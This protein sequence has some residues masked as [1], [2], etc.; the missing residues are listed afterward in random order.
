MSQPQ[1]RARAEA[2]QAI[3]AR[4]VS[5]DDAM[6]EIRAAGLGDTVDRT[7]KVLRQWSLGSP[8]SNLGRGL[9]SRAQAEDKPAP[10]PSADRTFVDPSPER[11]RPPA[12]PGEL[13][14]ILFIP[15]AHHPFVDREAWGVMLRAAKRFRPDVVVILGDFWDCYAVSAHDKDP[16][17]LSS[18]AS[19]ADTVREA[20]DEVLAIG[21]RRICYVEGN[22]EWRLPRYIA[23]QAQALHGL[24]TVP[25]LL[26]L[27]ERGIEWTPYMRSLRIGHLTITHDVGEAGIY[28]IK[29]ARDA[30]EGNIVIGHVHAMGI[31]YS[32]SARGVSRVG[33]AFGWLGQS[34]TAGD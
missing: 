5:L 26:G 24:L 32:G 15:D 23:K 2:I 17:R 33:A 14:R 10:A 6:A 29:R 19:E 1:G 21:A 28:A 13:Q 30:A 31:H 34:E 8:T 7:Y 20:L 11:E 25:E 4:H 3:F 9:V 16:A 27:S 22:H 12:P 18:L